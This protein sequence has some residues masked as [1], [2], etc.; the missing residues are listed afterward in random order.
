VG[1]GRSSFVTDLP[2]WNRLCLR[3]VNREVTVQRIAFASVVL[4]LLTGCFGASDAS[5][6]SPAATTNSSAAVPASPKNRSAE[7]RDV[8]ADPAERGRAA[9]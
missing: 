9:R 6:T 5:D 2:F 3:R 7:A 4:L 8:P 1:L